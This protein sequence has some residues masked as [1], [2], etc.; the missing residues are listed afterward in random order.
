M[1][2]KKLTLALLFVLSI[3]L[4]ACTLQDLPVI[5]K[6]FGN[7][8]SVPIAGPANL[9]MWG[10]WE[11]PEVMSVLINDFQ[12]KNSRTTVEYEDRS[13]LRTADYKERIFARAGSDVGADIVLVHNTWVPYLK[14][15]L[16]PMPSG[17]MSSSEY[18]E[19][20][21]PVASESAVIGGNI[22]AIPFYYDG[23]VLVYNKSHFDQIGQREAPT[24][25][26]E[27]RR[28]ALRLTVREG[29]RI[30]RAGAAIGNADNN[31]F[32]SDILGL[33]L[34]QTNVTIPQ[35]LDSRAAQDAVNFYITFYKDD[36]V[37]SADLPE[38]TAAF[39][40][41]RVSMIFVPSWRLLDIIEA[42]PGFDIGV[43]PVPQ[44]LPDRPVTWGSF[45]MMA[46]P[47]TSDN[48]A[49]AWNFI[50]YVTQEE[51]E[52]TKYNEALKF[53]GYGAPYARVSLAP[54]LNNHPYLK[55]LLDTAPYAKS[56]EIAG[57]AGNDRQ[58]E[59]FRQAINEIIK[60]GNAE[61]ELNK[62]KEGR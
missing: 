52:L 41:G 29:G 49:A 30:E 61:Q 35:G 54:Q 33:M 20:F 51:Q 31:D 62:L 14:D 36:K 22:Y 32:F 40:Q 47:V 28:L 58:V 5:G 21:Y 56:S 4:T 37:W 7:G 2:N 18:A 26:E 17:M 11:N 45:W 1:T 9:R 46:V 12:S 3:T 8:V 34:A 27:F 23:L 38:A 55:P 16:A 24:A 59:A 39:T 10:L 13:V 15:Y 57:R 25:W 19:S 48:T 42:D 53:R 43:A 44:A 6:Y 60:T 50:N